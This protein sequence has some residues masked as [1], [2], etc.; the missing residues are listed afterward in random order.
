MEKNKASRKYVLFFMLLC[1]IVYFMSYLTRLNYAAGLAEIRVSMEIS[2]QLASLPVTGCFIFY[3]VGQFIC[4][5]LGDHISPR[6]MIFLGLA[7]TSVCNLFVAFTNHIWMLTALWCLNGFFQSMLW[8]PLVRIM[9]TTLSEADYQKCCVYVSIASSAGTIAVYLLA[10]VCISIGNGMAYDGWRFT[11]LF[12]ALAGMLTAF[13]WYFLIPRFSGISG[14]RGDSENEQ[15]LL[16]ASQAGRENTSVPAET[17][18]PAMSMKTLIR[19]SSL[20][21]IQAAIVFHGI[22]RDGITTWMPAYISENFN[23]ST[24]ISILTTAVLP[25]FGIVSILAAS[26]LLNYLRNEVLTAS[27]LFILACISTIILLP[28]HQSSPVISVSMMTLITGCMHGINLMLISRVPRH[29][30][31]YGRVSTVSGLLN[32]ST[33]VG[34]AL[35]TYGFAALSEN[36]GWSFTIFVWLLVAVCGTLLCLPVIKK[37]KRFCTMG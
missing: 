20:L 7:A 16:S 11:F 25:L 9:A 26:I 31:K 18:I 21:M 6:I 17:K 34:S 27:V 24:S 23:I 2:K 8:P 3:G 35:S 14:I 1:C 28:F 4:G 19:T 5:I 30:A 32:A 37:W 33:Y 10:P 22:L 12:P 15:P 29:F 13:V 36:F